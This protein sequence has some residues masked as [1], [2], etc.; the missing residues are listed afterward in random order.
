VQGRVVVLLIDCLLFSRMWTL[1]RRKEDL[2]FSTS[3]WRDLQ[4]NQF[5]AL[6][7][8]IVDQTVS[9]LFSYTSFFTLAFLRN[10]LTRE[11]EKLCSCSKEN[12]NIGNLPFKGKISCFF[13]A[14]KNYRICIKYEHFKTQLV[15]AMDNNEQLITTKWAFLESQF[16]P[17]VRLLQS[18]EKRMQFKNESFISQF[19]IMKI[20]ALL[21]EQEDQ[22][23]QQL[24][25]KSEVAEGTPEFLQL[26]FGIEEALLLCI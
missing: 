25:S 1:E 12:E 26:V 20:I 4:A 15:I 3:S 18:E 13:C 22:Q 8:R 7:T 19:I 9:S 5:F 16:V 17:Q 11:T 2:S 21:K 10:Q 14:E 23:T 6:Q 24:A